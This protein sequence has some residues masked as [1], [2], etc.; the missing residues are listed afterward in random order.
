MQAVPFLMWGSSIN[1]LARLQ[2][3]PGFDSQR[4]EQFF[5]CATAWN[6]LWDPPA[7]CPVTT[8]GKVAEA[9]K[10]T[11]QLHLMSRLKMC[12]AMPPV[13]RTASL[14]TDTTYLTS[15]RS[16]LSEMLGRS[17]KQIAR[18]VLEAASPTSVLRLWL[19]INY[20]L[21][22][23]VSVTNMLGIHLS[24][25]YWWVTLYCFL[26]SPF[27]FN[28]CGGTLGTAASTGLL[29]QPRVIVKM[30][31]Q[32]QMECRLAEETEVLG[33]NLPQRHFCPSQNPTWPDPGLN[34]GRRG[35]KPAT[36]RLS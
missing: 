30:I 28:L 10:L 20:S 24:A 35:G 8:E 9:W 1:I 14:S 34:P 15:A 16:R 22:F 17:D 36:N 29:C 33:E 21:L 5:F 26:F 13:P 11:N 3:W 32:K 31:M 27:F 7:S 12:G 4:R 18:R 2:T 19:L 25:V 23:Q 6:R